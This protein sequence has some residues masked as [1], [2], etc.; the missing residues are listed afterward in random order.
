M[1]RSAT[2]VADSSSDE[3]NL[4]NPSK[5]PLEFDDIDLNLLRV[6]ILIMR[7]GSLTAAG[8]VMGK[9]APAMSQLLARLRRSLGDRLFESSG[10]RMLPTRRAEELEPVVRA[11]LERL[12]VELTAQ[13]TFDALTTRRTFVIDI[14][15]GADFVFAPLL[16]QYSAENA[17][18]VHFRIASDRSSLLRT[19][20]RTGE[21]ELAIDYGRLDDDD[22]RR[23]PLYSDPFVVLARRGHPEIA[24]HGALTREVF[25]AAGYVAVNSMRTADK[26]PVDERLSLMGIRR[27]T[28]VI[29]PSMA[30]MPGI[31]ETSD[32]LAVMSERVGRRVQQRWAVEVHPIPVAIEPIPLHLVWHKRFDGDPG[33]EWLRSA[34]CEVV[35][36]I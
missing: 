30:S 35:D 31:V 26:G 19:E 24:R 12:R 14:P 7:E 15:I 6:F 16:L 33:H 23:Q 27:N 22:M 2:R 32:L 11:T 29:V 36:L 13:R 17:P 25:E 4:H 10:H 28:A 20:L 21:T 5:R 1:A 34:I 3:P 9:K 18:H 8:K